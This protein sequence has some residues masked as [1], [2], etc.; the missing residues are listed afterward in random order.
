MNVRVNFIAPYWVNTPLVQA[1]V[2]KLE[3]AGIK[4]GQGFTFADIDLVVDAMVRSATDETVGGKAWGIWPGGYQDLA[5]DE[6]GRWAGDQL[7][8][9]MKILREMGDYWVV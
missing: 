5:D 8:E 4:P 9:Q 3:A 6:D 2:P 1:V 7:R